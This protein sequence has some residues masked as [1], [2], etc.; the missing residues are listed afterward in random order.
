MIAREG[1]AR[2]TVDG[3]AKLAGVTKG[4]LFHH[5]PSKQAL[6]DGVFSEMLSEV[7]GKIDAAMLTDPEPHGSF[8]REYLTLFL[9][10]RDSVD[11]EM[12]CG[13]CIAMLGDPALQSGWRDWLAREIIRHADTDD[14]PRCEIARLAA[15][16]IW[17][18]TLSCPL[19]P[20][21]I[22]TD[23]RTVLIGLTY[24]EH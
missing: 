8:T 2:L 11:L 23:V 7:Q 9:D 14:N 20:P 12:S 22:S 24:P 21:P 18:A 6:V 19:S 10:P 4:G 16:G 13:L 1:F 17:L 15:D 5:F 3:V